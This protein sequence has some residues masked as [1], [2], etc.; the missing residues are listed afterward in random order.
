MNGHGQEVAG[1]SP[2]YLRE[3]FGS[4]QQPLLNAVYSSAVSGPTEPGICIQCNPH[5]FSMFSLIPTLRS[6]RSEHRVCHLNTFISTKGSQKFI[7]DKVSHASTR[8]RAVCRPVTFKLR[9]NQS[10]H[11]RAGY[12]PGPDAAEH[13]NEP[14]RG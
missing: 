2:A 4:G 9:S 6:M 13:M 10:S 1:G 14:S 5:A 12:P 8:T 7:K 3:G 11:G